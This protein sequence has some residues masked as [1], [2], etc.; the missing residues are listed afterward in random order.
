MKT[1]NDAQQTLTSAEWLSALMDGEAASQVVAAGTTNGLTAAVLDGARADWNCY[2]AI[3]DVLT[4]PSTASA[5]LKYGADPA[6]VQRLMHRIDR[7][8]MEKPAPPSGGAALNA[9]NPLA[10]PS[11]VAANDAVF[12]WKLVAG[13]ASFGAVGAVVWALLGTPISGPTQLASSVTNTELIVASPQGPMVRDSRL[14][15]L[16]LAHK[17]LGSTSLQVPSGFLRSAGFESNNI[18]RR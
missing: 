5:A 10:Q 2:Q 4:V 16:V 9:V 13:F 8:P 15:E 18:D 3:S 17:Q 14:E 12:R 1:M 6:F 11:A 7:E